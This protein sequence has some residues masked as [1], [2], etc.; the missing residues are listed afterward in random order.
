MSARYVLARA[1]QVMGMATVLAGLMLSVGLGL[2]DEGLQSMQYELYALA[3]GGVLFLLGRL[4]QRR[5]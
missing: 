4:L 5:S 3:G 2:R 1:L